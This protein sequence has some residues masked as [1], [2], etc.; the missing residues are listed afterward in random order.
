M[1]SQTVEL[2]QLVKR[3]SGE[4]FPGYL[5]GKTLL[6]QLSYSDGAG[7][8]WDFCFYNDATPAPSG[9]AIT[10][11]KMLKA[12]PAG[13]PVPIHTAMFDNGTHLKALF[14]NCQAD[15][16]DIRIATDS[17]G[18][19]QIPFELIDIDTTDSQEKIVG[20]ARAPDALAINDYLYVVSQGSGGS[21][22]QPAADHAIGKNAVWQDFH[23][24][25][26]GMQTDSS[27]NNTL[28]VT[29]TNAL[30]GASLLN[31]Y[32]ARAFGVTDGVGITDRVMTGF[33]TNLGVHSFTVVCYPNADNG[34]VFY[35]SNSMQAQR[36]TDWI[37]VF[38]PFSTTNGR[39]RTSGTTADNEWEVWSYSWANTASTDDPVIYQDG[40]AST[41]VEVTAPAGAPITS[42]NELILGNDT[43]FDSAFGGRLCAMRFDTVVRDATWHSL[44]ADSYLDPGAIAEAEAITGV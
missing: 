19:T 35:R 13:F 38:Q 17:A 40:S 3:A 10:P 31:D 33:L 42:T 8:T 25:T 30:S 21:E 15:G 34:I 12:V 43:G 44:V 4:T 20:F 24:V 2:L 26:H 5:D 27:G 14:D 29:G 37:N 22:T 23:L 7:G 1:V 32:P 41:I 36:F 16:G 6:R 11:I 18:S 39:W 9:G 28:T